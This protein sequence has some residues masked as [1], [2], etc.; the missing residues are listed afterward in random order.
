[1]KITVLKKSRSH[2]LRKFNFSEVQVISILVMVLASPVLASF[3]TYQYTKAPIEQ[4]LAIVAI[5]SMQAQLDQQ[6][7]DLDATK[8]RSQLKLD[9]LTLKFGR[10][11]AEL[12]R[13]NAFGQRVATLAK[14][15]KDEFDFSQPPGMG[16]PEEMLEGMS[17][18]PT[19]NLFQDLDDFAAQL[20][21]RA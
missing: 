1:M 10:L 4:P 11:Q 8:A 3:L 17:Q 13:I 14:V 6:M 7:Q 12:T 9:A 21:D 2:G 19:S 18:F 16:G 15:N 20:N 5:E